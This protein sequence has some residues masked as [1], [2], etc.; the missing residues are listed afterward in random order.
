MIRHALRTDRP[1]ARARGGRHRSRSASASASTPR[2]SRGSRRC[3][4]SRFPE[5]TTAAAS[6]T[7]SR[8]PTPAPIPGM[9]WAEYQ[10]S[11]AD[12]CQSIEELVAFRMA[13][14][15][16]GETGR[17]ERDLRAARVRKSLHRA[18]TAARGRDGSSRADDSRH[19]PAASRWWC[20]SHDYWQTHFGGSPSAIGQTIRVNDIRADD[21]RRRA[22][23]FPGTILGA[24]I[25]SCGCRRRWR[26]GVVCRIDRSSTI[27]TS[28]ATPR[29]AAFDRARTNARATGGARRRR[30]ASWPASFP[31]SNGRIGGAL[32]PYWKRPRGPQLMFITASR[33]PAGVMLLVL[34]AV[35]GNTANLVL[36]R[37]SARHRE[38]SASAWRSAP[39][40]AT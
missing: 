19:V 12:A 24:A 31:E 18:R 3:C 10:R 25:R 5:S 2:C 14:L 34:L 27:A 30:C 29:S 16:V 37:A 28:A 1:H 20:I 32:M 4:S 6:I 9:S 11:E 35:C 26:H 22:R 39:A 21:H 17:T 15:N 13:P 36:A 40:R 23:G 8:S 33:H 7:S 38:R